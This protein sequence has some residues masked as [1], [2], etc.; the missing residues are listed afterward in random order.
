MDGKI[1]ALDVELF[2]NGGNSKDVSDAVRQYLSFHQSSQGLILLLLSEMS[3]SFK[4]FDIT[5][6]TVPESTPNAKG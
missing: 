5:S 4:R 2:V 1:K 6:G 3:S